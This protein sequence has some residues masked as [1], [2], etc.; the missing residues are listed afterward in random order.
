V[1]ESYEM[2]AFGSHVPVLESLRPRPKRVLEFG[3]GDHSTSAFLSMKSVTRLV[4]VETDIGWRER[5]SNEHRKHLKSGRWRL[6]DETDEVPPL[7][8]F[9][10][11]FIDDG[12]LPAQRHET[13]ARVLGQKHPRVVIHDADYAPYVESIEAFSS[14]F[15]IE[16]AYSPYTAVVDAN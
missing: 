12:L 14:D 7:T 1:A 3:V 6:L 15:R 8:D 2:G 5:V 13:I 11:V 16:D 10:L 9:D 4:S